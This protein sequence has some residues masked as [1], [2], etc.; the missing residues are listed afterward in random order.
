MK[1]VYFFLLCLLAG[2]GLAS[3]QTNVSLSP[4]DL[5][6]PAANMLTFTDYQ[7][8]TFNTTALLA[9]KPLDGTTPLAF[10]LKANG[11]TL[12]FRLTPFDLRGPGYELRAAGTGKDVGLLPA[13]PVSQFRGQLDVPG[14]GGALFTID[15]NFVIGTWQVGTDRWHLEPLWRFWPAAPRDAYVLYTDADTRELPGACGVEDLDNVHTTTSSDRS[16]GDCLEVEIALASDFSMYQAFGNNAASVENFILNGLAD[17]QSNYDNEFDDE[18]NFVVIA[19]LIVTSSAQDPWTSSTDGSNDLLPDFSAW[20]NNGGFGTTYD[21]ASLWTDRDLDGSAIGW[22]YIG[23]VCGTARY[24]ILQNFSNNASRLRVLWAHELGHNFGSNHDSGSGDI[25]APSVSG[26]VTW[27]Q[28]SQNAINGYYQ[29]ENCLSLCPNPDPPVAAASTPFNDVCTGSLV[30]FFDNSDGVV[31]TR[32]WQFPGATPSSS[33]AVAPTVTY[34]GPGSYTATLSVG[35]DFGTDLTT[36]IVRV[37]EATSEAATVL[38]H[39]TFDGDLANYTIENPDGQNT[40][41]TVAVIGNTGRNAAT[42]NNYDNNLPGAVDRLVFPAVDLSEVA[43]PTLLVE[44][45]YRRYSANLE[46]ELR[47][48]V[49]TMSG[50]QTVFVGNENGTGNFATGDDLQ[51]RFSPK[52][53][54]DWCFAGPQCIEI[55]LSAFAGQGPA[56]IV[57]ENENGYG[58]FLYVDNVM[59]FGNCSAGTLPVEWLTFRAEVRGKTATALIWTVLQDAAHAGFTVQRADVN[60]P[61]NWTDLGWVDAISGAGE[62]AYQ[63]TDAGVRSGTGYQ[64][65]LRQEDVDGTTSFSPIR[66]V[67]F[68]AATELTVRPNP[69]TGLLRLTTVASDA[70]Y[71]LYDLSGKVLRSGTTTGQRADLD[72]ADLPRAVYLL[73]VAEEVI[74]VVKQ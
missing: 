47:I 65:R 13:N 33:T 16:V 59:V 9:A 5:P 35:N 62:A 4:T 6:V 7:V 36:V 19:T 31:T 69:T 18:L 70:H 68:A 22:G 17:V 71:T 74:R 63:F 58:N 39:E 12:P 57:I 46:D 61:G 73:R 37:E 11:E 44:Y 56:E 50:N 32:N 43:S 14:G 55:D 64:Y 23:A 30:T 34:P 1:P 27:S 67:S 49:N 51:D 60:A 41:E 15:E 72:L 3:A 2:S 42:I 53:A 8:V 24:N 25:M 38:L 21:V 20:G 28:Q 29:S 48:V 66:S 52:N 54:D 26:A 10:E 40:W 45:A